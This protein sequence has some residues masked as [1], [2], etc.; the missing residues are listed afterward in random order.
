M[1]Q[2]VGRP[3][4]DNPKNIR[5]N[6]RLT[7]EEHETMIYVADRLGMTLTEAIVTT[8]EERARKIRKR[9]KNKV[10]LDKK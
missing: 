6:L 8:M 4:V 7:K 10:L 2:K 3:K 1:K 5:I 9:E